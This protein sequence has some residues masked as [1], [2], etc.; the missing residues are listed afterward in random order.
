M[1]L[2]SR[3]EFTQILL[4]YKNVLFTDLPFSLMISTFALSERG[5]GFDQRCMWERQFTSR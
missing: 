2:I 3:V 5:Y 1:V 4:R